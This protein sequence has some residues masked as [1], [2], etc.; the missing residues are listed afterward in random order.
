[1]TC[2][3]YSRREGIWGVDAVFELRLTQQECNTGHDDD[4]KDEADPHTGA[5]DSPC[6]RLTISER[7]AETHSDINL[8][9]GTQNW[10]AGVWHHHRD[11]V[12]S[13]L[14]LHEGLKHSM[15]V[16]RGKGN[17]ERGVRFGDLWKNWV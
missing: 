4:E 1:M 12:I 7:V 13:R 9:I 16:W 5:E 17:G 14:Q 2:L 3:L 11:R 15:S 10:T 6:H 8:S